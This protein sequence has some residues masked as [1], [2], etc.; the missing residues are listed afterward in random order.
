KTTAAM[1]SDHS[2]ASGPSVIWGIMIVTSLGRSAQAAE[3]EGQRDTDDGEGL[4]QG[5]PDPGG[6]HHRAAG[7]RLTSGA[8]DDGTEDQADADARADGAQAVADDTERAGQFQWGHGAFPF[9]SRCRSAEVFAWVGVVAL[10][11]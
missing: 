4:G 8:L 11:R 1:I 5:E 9:V 3:D 6:A 2:G 7:L 10:T